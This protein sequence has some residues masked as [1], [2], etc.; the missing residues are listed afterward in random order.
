MKITRVSLLHTRNIT[1]LGPA[2]ILTEPGMYIDGALLIVPGREAGEAQRARKTLGIPL[3]HVR[4]IEFAD[5]PEEP[6]AA[7]PKKHLASSKRQ[8]KFSEQVHVNAAQPT[9]SGGDASGP[10]PLPAAPDRERD[11]TEE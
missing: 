7:L 11:P 10:A 8:K 5:E 4:A 3:I 9:A 2:E 6:T 1:G